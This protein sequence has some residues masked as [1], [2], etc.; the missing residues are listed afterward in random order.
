MRNETKI[1]TGPFSKNI[2]KYLKEKVSVGNKIESYIYS[3]KSFDTFTKENSFNENILTKELI[4]NWLKLRPNEKRTNQASRANVIRGFS[5][6]MNI[7]DK[8]SYVLPSGVYSCN[9]KYN[10]YIYSENEICLIF[11]K[12]DNLVKI[13]PNK[14]CKNYSSQIIFRLLYMCGL[15]ISEALN[16]KIKDYDKEQKL[17][18]IRNSKKNKDRIV[19]INEELN[20]LI[21][22]Y[23]DKFHTFSNDDV[24]LFS[25]RNNTHYTRFTI[26]KRFRVILELCGIEHNNKTLHSF[27]HTYAVHCLKKW[28]IENKNL[29]VYLPILKTF[30]GHDSFR[31]TAYYLKLT[32]DV[33]PNIIEIIETQYNNVIP[34]LEENYD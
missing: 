19:P 23:I 13:Q 28:V 21:I 29:M 14:K 18:I 26:Y 5:K 9:S 1:F 2:E 16:L 27:R 25:G 3:L 4:N 7:F 12:I 11:N 8:N 10:A 31:E 17:L 30:L 6:Y 34:R 32:S 24:Y 33:Y 20:N 15:R 22:N